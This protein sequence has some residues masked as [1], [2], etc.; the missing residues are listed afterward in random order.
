LLDKEAWG[1][2]NI[3]VAYFNLSRMEDAGR[4]LE[5]GLEL[6]ERIGDRAGGV[7]A[8]SFLCLARPTDRR[9]PEWL[10]RALEYADEAGD[11]SR[12]LTTLTTLAWP[13]FIRALW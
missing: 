1:H 7:A 12:Q 4:E 6:F 5:L 2:A 9:V 11:R 3:G 10:R 13:H 8:S